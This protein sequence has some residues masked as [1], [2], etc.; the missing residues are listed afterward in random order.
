MQDSGE[1]D[2]HGEKAQLIRSSS[3]NQAQSQRLVV[4]TEAAYLEE[5][6]E[7]MEDLEVGTCI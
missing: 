4:S 3:E 6:A 1:L 7:R 5:R 2:L